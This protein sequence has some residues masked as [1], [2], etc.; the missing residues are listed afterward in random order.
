MRIIVVG[1]GWSGCAAS[2]SA[3]KQG[4]EVFLVERTDMLLGTG[5]VGGIIRNNGRFTAAEE[6]IAMEGGELFHLM[7]QNVLHRNIDFPGNRH[8][9]LYNLA[10]MEPQVKRFLLQ[11]GIHLL[12]TTRMEDVEM[13]GTRIKAVKGKQGDEEFRLEGDVFIDTTGTTG[14]PAACHKYGNGCALCILRC[15]FFGGRVSLAA[16]AGTREVDGRQGNQIG[17]MSGSCILVKESIS[18]ETVNRLEKDGSAT[19]AIPNRKG[20]SGKALH[21]ACPQYDLP[22]FSENLVLLHPGQVRMMTPFFPLDALRQIPGFENAR[23]QDPYAGGM[24]N[25]VR[26]LGMPP[27]EDTLKVK[28]VENL[29][30]AGEKAGLLVG[31]TE[32]IATGTLA[33]FNAVRQMKR[34]KLLILPATLAV[35]EIISYAR[36][37]METVEGLGQKYTFSGSIYFERMK[38]KGLYTINPKEIQERVEASGLTGAFSAR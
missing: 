33:G 3:S 21:K 8:A 22:E 35:G 31:H 32:G 16:R 4:A 12:L 26:F 25:S 27:R 11:K 17:A 14:P 6:M 1:G 2:L 30:C 23:Y 34:E 19:V 37:E 18:R 38:Q 15:S 29:F 10:T 13:K 28:G 24:G 36:N 5:L 20:F 7:D 9:S